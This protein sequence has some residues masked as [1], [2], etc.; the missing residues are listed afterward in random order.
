M[1]NLSIILPFV[2][3]FFVSSCKKDDTT[4]PAKSKK[5]I[6][7]AKTWLISEVSA[8]GAVVYTK[9]GTDA[10]NLGFAKVSLKFNTDG[11][12]TG[13]DNSGKALPTNAKWALSSDETKIN[14]SNSG[15]TGLDGDVPIVQLNE[16]VLELKGKV[17][18]QGVVYDGNLKMIPQ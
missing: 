10:L 9:G 2:V 18:V 8:S 14:I 6:L 4:T 13:L 15:L 5:D 16:S 1:K 11:S 12:L 3:L 17:T 7:T